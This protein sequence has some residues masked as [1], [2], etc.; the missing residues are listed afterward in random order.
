M[1]TTHKGKKLRRRV[2]TGPV[3]SKAELL[4]D[5]L[6]QTGVTL[7]IKIKQ[8]KYIPLM[9]RLLQG[10]VDKTTVT[11]F[12]K[13]P[14]DKFICGTLES[15]FKTN[16]ALRHLITTGLAVLPD[17]TVKSSSFVGV[18]DKETQQINLVH[19]TGKIFRYSP[20]SIVYLELEKQEELPADLRKWDPR[21][22]KSYI[23]LSLEHIS[24]DSRRTRDKKN[25][26]SVVTA[27]VN[28]LHQIRKINSNPSK[29]QLDTRTKPQVPPQKSRR[30]YGMASASMS[31]SSSHYGT[32]VASLK[33]TKEK[34][35]DY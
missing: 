5:A 10:S 3:K 24:G 23:V 34:L 33:K 6:V 26:S 17:Q 28:G 19:H 9:D 32:P 30:A 25:P 35:F 29:K 20:G 16:T 14:E 21:I 1:K 31:L 7:P 12:L 22:S 4:Y 8:E 18:Y 13:L 11:R 27:G 2:K 15:V